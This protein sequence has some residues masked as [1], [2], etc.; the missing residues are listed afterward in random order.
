MTDS[1][2]DAPDERSRRLSEV[3][4]GVAAV[5]RRL[6]AAGGADVRLVAV[7]KGWG[8]LEIEAAVAAGV[9]DI[10]ENYA[11]EFVAKRQ[12]LTAGSWATGD[13][14]GV[15]WHFIGQLQRNK[16]RRLAEFVDV[17][18]T[19]DRASVAR[20]IARRH[21]GA[22]VF[23]QVNVSGEERKGGCQPDELPSL[24]AMSRDLGL[25]VDG[26]MAVGPTGPPGSALE[27]FRRLVAQADELGL[28]ER[29]LGMSADLEVAVTAGTTM[30]RVGRDIFGARPPPPSA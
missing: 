15:T 29:S 20:E 12:A 5:R 24:T 26:V 19:V 9:V 21:P 30:V 18:Q 7:T 10:G 25:R 14:V 16:V 4:E 11:Q 27:P 1:E 22:T 13:Q 28:P 2:S 3:A 6:A 17:W 23:I 8:A